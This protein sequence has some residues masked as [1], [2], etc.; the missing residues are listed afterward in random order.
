MKDELLAV[1]SWRIF[2][3]ML[4][5]IDEAAKNGDKVDGVKLHFHKYKFGTIEDFM[6]F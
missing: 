1:E 6:G 4:K 5:K 3:P 2:T